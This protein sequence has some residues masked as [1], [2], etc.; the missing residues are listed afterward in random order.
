MRD[1]PVAAGL[2]R[3]HPFLAS[4][5]LE[6][7]SRKV[8]VGGPVSGDYASDQRQYVREIEVVAPSEQGAFRNRKLQ[9]HQ[10]ADRKRMKNLEGL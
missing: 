9:N 2:H 4:G 3:S 10:L 6:Y 1:V 8:A 7:G 5:E